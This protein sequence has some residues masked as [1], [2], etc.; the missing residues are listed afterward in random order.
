[1][2][3]YWD[4]DRGILTYEEV[5]KLYAEGVYDG[6]DMGSLLTDVLAPILPGTYIVLDGGSKH[7]DLV[8][9][10]R[11]T[12]VQ[13]TYFNEDA[14]KATILCSSTTQTTPT[15]TVQEEYS[16]GELFQYCIQ[17]VLINVANIK[18]DFF[19]C[20][21]LD[22]PLCR[23]INETEDDRPKING[24]T[25]TKSG[26]PITEITKQRVG[27]I[28]GANNM[29]YVKLG[30][31]SMMMRYARG[32]LMIDFSSYGVDYVTIPDDVSELSAVSV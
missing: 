14:V 4:M 1:M 27:H 9:C 22:V 11:G 3:Y 10:L 19:A 13:L 29:F 21:K 23:R 20:F 28:L 25:Y 30:G 12:P 24:Y 2:K 6:T 7:A 31:E 17:K 15:I 32:L 26:F 16:N 18:Q 5:A 8:E